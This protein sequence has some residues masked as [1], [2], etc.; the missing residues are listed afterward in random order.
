MCSVLER[1]IRQ[2]IDLCNDSDDSDE[3]DRPQKKP[4]LIASAADH[5]ESRDSTPLRAISSRLMTPETPT[6]GRPGERCGTCGCT[7]G[8][9][10]SSKG[11]A[12]SHKLSPQVMGNILGMSVTL[13]P[14]P[15]HGDRLRGY[16]TRIIMQAS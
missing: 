2:V 12:G 7:C 9:P 6:S 16:D 3:E 4:R 10:G 15:K 5:G 8:I 13:S 11:G 14:I 1:L